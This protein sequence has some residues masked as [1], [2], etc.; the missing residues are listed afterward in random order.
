M[1]KEGGQ[2]RGRFDDIGTDFTYAH[3]LGIVYPAMLGS[4]T[5]AGYVTANPGVSGTGERQFTQW[6]ELR[7]EETRPGVSYSGDRRH[8]ESG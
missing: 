5:S 2:R 7:S 8:S 3:P 4:P 1:G 6:E